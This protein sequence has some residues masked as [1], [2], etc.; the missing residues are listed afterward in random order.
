MPA[1]PTA[2][3]HTKGTVRHQ[4]LPSGSGTPLVADINGN[5]FVS[6]APLLQNSCH[7]IGMVPKVTSANG[8]L[9][10]SQVFD[11]GFSVGIGTTGPFL[12][13]G[14]SPIFGTPA[15]TMKL[16]VAGTFR[17]VSV[18]VTSDAKY[19]TQVTSLEN[20]LDKVMKLNGV[21]YYWNF[22]KFSEK[23]FDKLKHSGFL[24]QEL[25]KVL[26]NSVIVDER[27]DY[28]VDYNSIIPVLAEAIKEQQKQIEDLKIQIA[29][30]GSTNVNNISSA[31]GAKLYQ[32]T[33]NPFGGSTEIKFYVPQSVQQAS[34]VIFDMTGKKL[35]SFALN[36]RGEDK[37]TV[38]G[39]ELAAGMYLYSLLADGKEVDTKRMILSR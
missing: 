1:M 36:N 11:D 30:Q 4:N 37:I 3:F 31:D 23:K 8:D 10:C 25:Q 33:P 27:G 22:E 14:G 7:T 6:S 38:S 24:A 26:P 5:V 39:D 13:G 21:E 2:D 34:I 32:N 29:Q 19:K 20:S 18:V 12:F 15:G 28:A 16:D 9:N 35:K 17:A